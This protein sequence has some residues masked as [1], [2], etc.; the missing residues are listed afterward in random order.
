MRRSYKVLQ[1]WEKNIFVSAPLRSKADAN[2][3]PTVG[4]SAFTTIITRLGSFAGRVIAAPSLRV[5]PMLL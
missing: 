3:G 2:A 4:L 1:K 5:K